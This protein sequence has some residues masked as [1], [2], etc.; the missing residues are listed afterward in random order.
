MALGLVLDVV[1]PNTT[2]PAH[3]SG[4]IGQQ[5]VASSL[6]ESP[7][8]GENRS[9]VLNGAETDTGGNSGKTAVTPGVVTSGLSRSRE[10]SDNLK[11]LK[12]TLTNSMNTV[13]SID[14]KD[15]RSE[16]YVPSVKVHRDEP[17]PA[18]SLTPEELHTCTQ[19]R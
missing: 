8:R 13:S 15:S 16:L 3:Q 11:S 5:T 1:Y 14:R 17:N 9:S 7:K 4:L 12:E 18:D 6:P 2:S 19:A 10:H